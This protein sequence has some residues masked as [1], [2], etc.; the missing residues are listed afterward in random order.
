M[1]AILSPPKVSKAPHAPIRPPHTPIERNLSKHVDIVVGTPGRVLHF[2]QS[3]TIQVDGVEA[4]VLDEAD[5]MLDTGF[6]KDLEL[7]LRLLPAQKQTVLFSATLP[8]W[9]REMSKVYFQQPALVD[10]V[11]SESR[12]TPDRVVHQQIPV[13]LS[14]QRIIVLSRLIARYRN[15]KMLVFVNTKADCAQLAASPLISF[16]G[17]V[18]ALH[19]DIKQ[20]ERASVLDG[21]RQG[22]H[23]VII[24][25]DVASR[26]LDITDIDVVVHYNIPKST[27]SYIHRS[28]RCGRAGRFGQVIS[29][30]G[31]K[32]SF[33]VQQIEKHVGFSIPPVDPPSEQDIAHIRSDGIRSIVEQVE[34]RHAAPYLDLADSLLQSHGK[35]ILAKALCV[36]SGRASAPFSYLNGTEGYTTLRVSSKKAAIAKVD[37]VTFLHKMGG[38]QFGLA[39]I[40]PDGSTVIDCEW[41]QVPVIMERYQRQV[42][43]DP[44]NPMR[45]NV[46]DDLPHV[47]P[48]E[49]VLSFRQGAI[50]MDKKYASLRSPSSPP[51]RSIP[52]LQADQETPKPTRRR[53]S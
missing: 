6:K 35:E 29:I 19:G 37:A 42:L 51:P 4:F 7:I 8:H 45:I 22:M 49:Q 21:F 39:Q 9:V 16:S 46:V 41:D 1:E 11:M 28:G 52:E 14:Q 38:K 47:T 53:K 32:E 20:E 24:A 5:Q 40:C 12:K 31:G 26:G 17:Q 33:L 15:E 44:K 30:V 13:S 2:I 18:R 23:N 25:T 48:S 27:E 10:L 50:D 43:S 36:L 34:D 3:N